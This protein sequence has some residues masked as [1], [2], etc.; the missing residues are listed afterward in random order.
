MCREGQASI[1]CCCFRTLVRTSSRNSR[2]QV[3]EGKTKKNGGLLVD[4]GREI[5]FWYRVRALSPKAEHRPACAPWAE[6]WHSCALA[7]A[8]GAAQP[9]HTS[10]PCAPA[11]P[12]TWLWSP[13]RPGCGPQAAGQD[14]DVC[15]LMEC[16][17]SK[18][19]CVGGCA[20][21]LLPGPPG[22]TIWAHLCPVC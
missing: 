10:C 11:A 8:P 2:K 7:Q 16:R 12:E 20:V 22:S 6:A 3:G 5:F 18:E 14:Q 9:V 21:P 19:L 17:M 15:V 1:I 13:G 4:L